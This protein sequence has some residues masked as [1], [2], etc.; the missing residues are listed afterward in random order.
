VP[1]VLD[2]NSS[3]WR[4]SNP[5][6]RA[7]VEQALASHSNF[8]WLPRRLA[9]VTRHGSYAYGT[10]TPTSDLDVKGFVI[11]PRE[12]F[13]G[14]ANVFEQA[15][16]TSPIDHAFYDIRKFFRLA[17][18]CNPSIIEVLFTAPEDH[19]YVSPV[20]ESV[21]KIRNSFLSRKAKHTFCGY[22]VSQ[23][24]RIKAHR[25][26]LL[27][28]MQ[29]PPTRAEFGLPERTVIPRD[30]LMAAESAVGKLVQKWTTMDAVVDKLDAAQKIEL[31][32]DVA[33]MMASKD[34]TYD[35]VRRH[36][37]ATLGYDTNFLALLDRE[38][39][40]RTQHHEW[41]QYQQWRTTRNPVRAALEE[42]HGYDC[43]HAS[44]LYRLLVMCREILE[45]K[46]VIVKRPDREQILAIRQGAWSYDQLVEWA[47]R[48]DAELTEV[49]KTSPLPR[50]PDRKVLDVWLTT[51]MYLALKD[52]PCIV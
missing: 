36:A 12:Y 48:Q 13:L 32:E 25:R 27:N 17:A 39:T 16:G 52:D 7:L 31:Q 50:E 3:Y 43:K 26:W 49:M 24:K 11:P 30:Q 18:D 21:L 37:G 22:A 38:R 40:Y 10:N 5:N 44:Q 19:I 8:P 20:G 1:Q 28:P 45:G 23:L 4:N 42:K 6:D 15:D 41:E 29:A 14:F 33:R 47:E 9:F 2:T 51:G 35:D 46:G 34:V